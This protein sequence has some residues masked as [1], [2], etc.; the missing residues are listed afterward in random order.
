VEK[1][2]GIGISYEKSGSAFPINGSA[3]IHIYRVLQ[4]ALNNVARHAG[5]N[6]AWVRLRFLADSAELEVEDQGKGFTKEAASPGIGLVEMRERAQLLGGRLEF[7]TPP[8][9]GTRVRLSVPRKKV[10]AHVE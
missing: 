6:R 7:T 2:T 9:G 10:E 8:G 4:E 5:V 1:Q 3:S